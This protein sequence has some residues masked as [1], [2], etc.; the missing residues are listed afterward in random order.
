[1]INKSD[2]K[3]TLSEA[4]IARIVGVERGRRRSWAEAGLMRL[5]S[6][7]GYTEL[8][9]CEAAVF[10]TLV[11]IL[12]FDRAR[13]AWG[14]IRPQLRGSLLTKPLLVLFDEGRIEGALVSDAKQLFDLVATG[15]R[16]SVI[17]ISGVV[18]DARTG[19][20]NAIAARRKNE[21]KSDVR[22]NVQEWRNRGVK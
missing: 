1:M 21:G 5:A 12:E 8:D 19:F 11:A 22:S 9:A 16:F 10:R 2:G 15:G 6:R 20:R 17:E 4:T 3:A 18:A 14:G 13:E 7:N